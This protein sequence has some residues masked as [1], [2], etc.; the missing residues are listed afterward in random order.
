MTI[1]TDGGEQKHMAFLMKY[2]LKGNPLRKARRMPWKS[3][4]LDNAYTAE[5]MRK[6]PVGAGLEKS[7]VRMCLGS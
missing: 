1:A 6:V 2:S 5:V 3:I 4:T 7:H